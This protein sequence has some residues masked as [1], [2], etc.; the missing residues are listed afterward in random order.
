M[1]IQITLE[2][3]L[4]QLS[5][6]EQSIAKIAAT[7]HASRLR[8]KALLANRRSTYTPV[9][10]FQ[11]RRDT[12]RRMVSKYSEQLVYRPLEEM[13]YWFTYSSGAFLEPGYPPLFYSRT[14]QRRMTANKS[15]VAGI[16]EGIAGFLAQR[17]Y[18][19][20]KLA[21]PNH[22]Y[23]DIVMQGN[24]NTYL[25]EAKATTDSTLGIKQVLE[26]ELVR[27]AGYISACAEL[28]TRPVVGILVGTA[29]MSETDYRCYIT[30]V[31]L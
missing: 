6:E 18:Q 26:D 19:C 22:D 4:L 14:E 28:D 29:L 27:M 30:E 9:G 10:S 5:Q 23:P 15:A 2:H 20:R 1:T 17:Y 25:I 21:R 11:L 12:L 31:A 24:G 3:R 16:G 8:F 13:Q 7:R